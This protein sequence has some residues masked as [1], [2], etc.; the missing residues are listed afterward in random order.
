MISGAFA[1]N[2][3]ELFSGWE[4]QLNLSDRS[5]ESD[6]SDKKKSPAVSRGAHK[7]RSWHKGL[8][9]AGNPPGGSL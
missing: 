6:E 2:A 3:L 1:R 4:R 5:D 7:V 8:A 9:N